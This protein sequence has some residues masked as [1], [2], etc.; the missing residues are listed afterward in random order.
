MIG[1]GSRINSDHGKGQE[2]T[3]I[4]GEDRRG[5]RMGSGDKYRTQ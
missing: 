3:V 5:G 2:S 1:R 4:M